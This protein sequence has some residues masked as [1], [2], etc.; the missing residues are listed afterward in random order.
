MAQK[1]KADVKKAVAKVKGKGKGK[2]KAKQSND[3]SEEED[4]LDISSDEPT[5]KKKVVQ[6]MPTYVGSS[7]EDE[8]DDDDYEAPSP[9]ADR[10]RKIKAS[11]VADSPI[12]P[13]KVKSRGL[14]PLSKPTAHKSVLRPLP[15]PQ[16]NLARSKPAAG[17]PPPPTMER[18]GAGSSSYPP[19]PSPASSLRP[20]ADRELIKQLSKFGRPN[21]GR[22]IAL[23]AASGTF[24][25]IPSVA[26]TAL[27]S[28]DATSRSRGSRH[29]T[30][31]DKR[32]DETSAPP[33]KDAVPAA[34]AQHPA[35]SAQHPGGQDVRFASEA[36]SPMMH[37]AHAQGLQMHAAPPPQQTHAAPLPQGL[38]VAPAQHPGGQDA[39]FASEAP[40]PMMHAA[41]AQGL[42]MHAAQLPQQMYAA[43]P[44]QGLQMH[45]APG[46][47]G[48]WSQPTYYQHGYA[49]GAPSGYAQG[50]DPSAYANV[51]HPPPHHAQ[52][53]PA[54]FAGQAYPLVHPNLPPQPPFQQAGPSNARG[55][56]PQALA[57]HAPDANVHHHQGAA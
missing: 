51:Y 8:D 33:T 34:S 12:P 55:P 5:P 28:E 24:S 47:Q 31:A 20:S 48:Y 7:S 26:A 21:P 57:A 13:R 40:S 37:A 1:K 9:G 27:V 35:A 44:P 2:G 45:A 56:S 53:V 14:I 15:R 23:N 54:G 22:G 43:Q 3:S 52:H 4:I 6:T 30:P 17:P 50:Y 10:K 46:P 32:E 49:Q 16:F 19:S 41:H 42:Q 25:H 18:A 39:R 38:H 11:S 36:P 29:T